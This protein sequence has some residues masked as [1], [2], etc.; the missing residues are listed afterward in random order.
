MKETKETR[1]V[2]RSKRRRG[3]GL[4]RPARAKVVDLERYRGIISYWAAFRA[5]AERPEP[6]VLRVR[7]GRISPRALLDRLAKRGFVLRA[8][9]GLRGFFEVESGPGPVSLTLEHWL[10]LFYVQQAST[11]VAALSIQQNRD[12][13]QLRVA[14]GVLVDVNRD[15]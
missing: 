11:G 6:T 14:S 3:R 4:K 12:D 2:S 10:G 9:E 7:T 5:A 1:A 8:K 13:P 15:T